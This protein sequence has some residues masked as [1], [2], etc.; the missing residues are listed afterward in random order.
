MRIDVVDLHGGRDPHHADFSDVPEDCPWETILYVPVPRT[1]PRA[2][3]EPLLKRVHTQWRRT[4]EAV[5]FRM[6]E[7]QAQAFIDDAVVVDML[8][9]RF[10]GRPMLLA[11]ARPDGLALEPLVGE[12]DCYRHPALLGAFRFA[13]QHALLERP[14][15][16]LP[17]ND[18]FHYEG[19]NGYRYESFI[20]VGTAIQGID[21]LD[22]IA[23]WLTPYTAGT[24][25]VVLDSWTIISLGLNLDRYAAQCGF[26]TPAISGLECPRSYTESDDDLRRRLEGFRERVEG[27]V[28]PVMLLSSVI[29]TGHLAGRLADVCQAA[30]F[31]DIRAVGIFGA[32]SVDAD[33]MCRD[34]AVGQYW[35]PQDCPLETPE[36]TIAASTYLLELSVKPQ[37]TTIR[38]EHAQQA[39]DFFDRYRGTD[40]VS[41]H[42][43]QHDSDRHHMVYIDVGRLARTEAFQPRLDECLERM[44]DIDVVLAPDHSAAVQLSA[45]VS[46]ALGARHVVADETVLPKLP[47]DDD[48]ALRN[49]RRILLVDDCL[50][51]GARLRGYRHFLRACDFL[52]GQQPPEIHLLV[53]VARVDDNTDLRGL[54]DM[55]DRSDRFYPVET[56]LLPN[57]DE[58]DC[59]W[60]WEHRQLD[61]LR[62][63]YD[64]S[65]R[66]ARRIGALEDMRHGMRD[67]L[68]MPW[69]ATGEALPVSTWE[70]GPDSIFHADTQAEL[71]A[72]VA[73]ATQSLRSVGDLSERPL[74]P[75]SRVL[76][77][78]Y[79]L[80]G[81]YY[82]PVLTACVL[83]C[84]R[85]HDLR[86]ASIAPRLV[87]A[88]AK[89]LSEDASLELR[90]E[91]LFAGG[92]NL[93]PVPALGI[94]ED[95]GVL[96][97][98]QADPGISGFLRALLDRP[99]QA[100]VGS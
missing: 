12:N 47:H 63:N 13:E 45:R 6:H 49:A 91:L 23:F 41:V 92:R 61:A 70:L 43:D 67:E 22:A 97:D 37:E 75:I 32:E 79:W 39:W 7:P 73:S 8:R 85:R 89:R 19:P 3:L 60:C 28:P 83:R 10:E 84:T 24:P 66:V 53:G 74:Y 21:D 50:I 42:R 64:L 71:F 25:L 18:D 27:D 35:L 31:D 98:H 96:A 29:S 87:E 1:T 16:L 81:R 86:A 95:D 15:V 58:T 46:A 54:A 26:Q 56:L 59:P 82:D 5:V 65:E 44:P 20:R 55:V 77:P 9:R 52:A 48:A 72:A 38:I 14:G 69:S 99:G 11:R 2:S 78:G 34:E 94:S 93:L 40:C 76:D 88:M 57:W 17:A 30:G 4:A 62:D 33:V 36:V 68:F 51:T 90:A 80:T 100:G